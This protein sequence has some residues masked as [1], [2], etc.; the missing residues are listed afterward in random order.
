MSRSW[1]KEEVELRVDLEVTATWWCS[2]YIEDEKTYG[3][4]ED[5]HPGSEENDGDL[6]CVEVGSVR[7]HRGMTAEAALQAV[8]D[9]LTEAAADT[10]GRMAEWRPDRE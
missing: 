2:G 6:L 3:P 1:T 4:P 5:C 8:K 9:I 7:L 10:I